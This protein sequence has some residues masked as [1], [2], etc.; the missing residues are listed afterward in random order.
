MKSKTKTCN[1]ASP[2]VKISCMPGDTPTMNPG[3]PCT[4][5]FKTH[6]CC[7]VSFIEAQM[8]PSWLLCL[9]KLASK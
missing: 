3:Q 8:A 5:V 4:F 2:S 9:L 7:T 1:S 6:Q